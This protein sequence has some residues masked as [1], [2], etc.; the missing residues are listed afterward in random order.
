MFGIIHYP[1][2]KV[3][4]RFECRSCGYESKLLA[5]LLRKKCPNCGGSEL[6]PVLDITESKPI[7][8]FVS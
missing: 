8:P 5:A 3:A 1:K 2:V 7:F 4:V 6:K